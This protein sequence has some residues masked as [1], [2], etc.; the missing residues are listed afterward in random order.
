LIALLGD[1]HLPRGSRRLPDACIELLRRAEFVL[2]TGDVTTLEALAALE[3]FG[4]P[5]RGVRGNMDEPA[6]RA[7]LPERLVV[8]QE[9]VRI[10]LVH[11]AGRREGRHERLLGWFPGCD[12]VAYGHTHVPELTRVGT[13][14]VV[15]PGS[16]TER[17][18]A[19]ARTMAVVED[20]RPRLVTLA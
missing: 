10:G 13:V 2:H 18:R 7:V 5:V 15:N 14:W 4:A 17:R 9:G 1:S 8:A 12:L 3:A 16:P 20:G 11:D 19:P 6:L